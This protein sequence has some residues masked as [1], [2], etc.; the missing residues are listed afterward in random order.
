MKF[1][2]S[3]GRQPQGSD[4]IQTGILLLCAYA[5]TVLTSNMANFLGYEMGINMSTAMTA[6]IY[7]KARTFLVSEKLD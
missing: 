2:I 6:L 5:V 1:L 4:A 7:S 3:Y